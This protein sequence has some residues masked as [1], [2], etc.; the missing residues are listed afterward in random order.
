MNKR[1]QWM[2]CAI[3]LC[4]LNAMPGWAQN[5]AEPYLTDETRPKGLVWLPEPPELTSAVFTYDFYYYQLGRQLR[6]VEG[7]SEQALSDESAKLWN[8]FSEVLD[9]Q[10]SEETTPEIV[11]LAESA[12]V[13]AK[14][15][16][17]V[18]KNHYQRIRPFAQFNE[19]SLK[20]WTD[21]EEAS[22]YSYPSGHASRGWMYA[23]VLASVIPEYAEQIFNRALVYADNRVICGHHWKT[24]IDASLMLA[25]GIFATIVSTDAFHAQQKKAR[26]EYLRVKNST[27][28]SSVKSRATDS[29]ASVYDLQGRRLDKTPSAPGIY[30][31]DGQKTVVGNNPS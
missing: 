30:I 11:L 12:I 20:P 10:L 16:N 29:S 4:A 27:A 28:V 18:V 31:V 19:P 7:V 17:T 15:A 1:I 21:E 6:E 25:A 5:Y 9:I 14:K 13:D 24:D 23:F 26:E 3:V 2:M 22:T 8:V